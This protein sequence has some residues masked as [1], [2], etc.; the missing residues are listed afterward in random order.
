LK[1][2]ASGWMVHNEQSDFPWMI[3]SAISEGSFKHFLFFVLEYLGES[4]GVQ[5]FS[6]AGLVLSGFTGRFGYLFTFQCLR[7]F[8]VS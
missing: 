6:M 8:G 1:L 5:G 7:Y 4:S 3:E 2:A